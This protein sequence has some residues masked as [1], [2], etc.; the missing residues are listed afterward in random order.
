MRLMNTSWSFLEKNVIEVDLGICGAM[1]MNGQKEDV[2]AGKRV[3][4]EFCYGI[5]TQS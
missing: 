2:V 4:I 3:K 5:S 1:R